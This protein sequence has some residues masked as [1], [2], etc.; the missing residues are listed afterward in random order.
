MKKTKK[1]DIQVLKDGDE[2]VSSVCQNDTITLTVKKNDGSYK[3]FLIE[4]NDAGLFKLKTDYEICVSEEKGAPMIKTSADDI[5]EKDS[6]S[7]IRAYT[8]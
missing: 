2:L 5:D 1:I 4:K 6:N 8:L 3:I 7:S